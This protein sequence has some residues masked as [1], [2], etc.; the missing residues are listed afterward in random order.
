M[1]TPFFSLQQE[2][3]EI[4]DELIAAATRV[5]QSGHYI[6]GPEVARFEAEFAGYCGVQHCVGV[7]N[8][9][10]AIVL[11]LK[12]MDIGSGDEVIVPANTFIATWLAVTQVGA[13][14]VPV[15]P[16]TDSCNIDPALIEA[17]ITPRTR[18]IIAVHLYGLPANM[19]RINTLARKHGL[20]VIEDAAQAHGARLNDIRAGGLSDAASFS[21]YPA[22]NLGA[23]GDAGA[24]VCNDADLAERVRSLANYG[25]KVKY[26]HDEA[27]HNS[28]LDEIQAALL[29]V[30]LK[31]LDATIAMRRTQAAQYLQHL[32]ADKYTL[33]CEPAGMHHSWHQFVIRSPRRD[34]VADALQQAGIGTLIHYPIAPA[35]SG[36][37]KQQFNPRDY[38]ITERMS[39]EV[40]SLPLGRHMDTGAL[41]AVCQTLNTLP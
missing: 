16:E 24:V 14:P 27:G 2:H 23:L 33:P 31:H 30:K 32:D 22:K 20:K 34:V 35:A 21:F 7:G 4:Q 15:E 18:A 9:L 10:E 5:I 39:A 17:A 12:A 6:L 37:Y 25:S 26:H 19:T 1:N 41:D 36:A 11:I 13:T 8:G 3:R 28:R 38:P 29:S 40:L